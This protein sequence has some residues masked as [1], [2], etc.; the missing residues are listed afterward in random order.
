MIASSS[1]SPP[2]RIDCETTIPPSEMT[3]T[4]LV[5]PPTSTTM[6][7]VGS[8]TGSPAPIAAAIGSSMRYAWRAP[9]ER[10]ASS[11]AR[12]STPVTPLGTHTTTR[13]CAQRFWWTFWM[14]WR[15][16]CSVTSKSA[17]TPSLSGR[18]AWIVPGVR[19]SMRLASMPTAW[20]SSVRES[21]ATTDGSDST[22]P[23]PRT[24]TS[25]F[26]VPRSTAMSRPPKPVRYEKKPIEV[27]GRRSAGVRPCRRTGPAPGRQ[28]TERLPRKPWKSA[29]GKQ[30]RTQLEQP[31]Q[32]QPDDVQIVALDSGDERC[33]APLDRVAAR[34]ALPL[35]RPHVPLERSPV[36]ASERHPRALDRGREQLAAFDEG[37]PAHHLVGA[38]GEAREEAPGSLLVP[39]LAEDVA[40]ERD[41]G[42]RAEHERVA[43]GLGDRECLAARV[44][45]G[46]PGRVAAR[47]LLH[48]RDAHLEGDPGLLEDRP[49]LRR[50]A[51]E[52]QTS[53]KN[54]FASRSADSGEWGPGAMFWPTSTAKSPRMEP[55][56]AS[57]GLVAPIT[58]RAATTAWS[59]SSTIATSGPE[60]MN[61]TSSPKNALPSCS[62]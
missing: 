33:A 27:E 40:V 36:E 35:P 39:R 11:T 26:A 44:L 29:R 4:S 31:R 55:G 5:P 24:Y 21:I 50:P 13:G 45:L 3:A 32:G 48:P 25:V 53:G 56:A 17:I 12:F 30:V 59:P 51:R 22:I 61:D 23:R 38:P 37:D 15:S 19:P 6:F 54:S 14:K 43:R 1:S 42:V 52:D 28:S 62:A 16:I 10:Q 7:P 9:A 20:T 8:P 34:A 46:H 18:I 49:P 41:V 47:L 58:W 57:S 60:V 2:M